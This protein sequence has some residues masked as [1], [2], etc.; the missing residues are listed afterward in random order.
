MFTFFSIMKK[1]NSK[2]TFLKSST[3]LKGSRQKQD[4]SSGRGLSPLFHAADTETPVRQLGAVM[5][6]LAKQ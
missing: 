1:G 2:Q 3:F 6:T 5:E 4:G